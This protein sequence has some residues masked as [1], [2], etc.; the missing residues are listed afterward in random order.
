MKGIKTLIGSLLSIFITLFILHF[1]KN[2]YPDL[3]LI[4]TTLIILLYFE[5]GTFLFFAIGLYDFIL[6]REKYTDQ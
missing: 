5:L 1:L 4:R 6:N 3:M 2:F